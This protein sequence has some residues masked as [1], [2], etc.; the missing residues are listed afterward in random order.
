[1]I[2]K[3]WVYLDK[4][5]TQQDI[6]AMVQQVKMP[7]IF[8]VA[9]YNRQVKPDGAESYLKRSIS[10]LANP[11]LLKDM[12]KAVARIWQA[13]DAGETIVIYGDYD[14]DGITSTAML[15]DFLRAEGANVCYYIPSRSDEGYGINIMA[16]QKFKKAGVN[17]V[18][19]VDCGITAVGEVAFANSIG[20]SVV[21]TDHHIC[22]EKLPK[23]CAV[24]NPKQPGDGHPFSE[25][26][27]VGLC[28]KLVLAL[29]IHHGYSTREYFDRY[30]ELCAIGTIAD[31]VPLVDENRIMVSAG[32]K[33]LAHTK[34][35]GLKAL[36]SAA[37]FGESDRK[38]DATTVSFG[39]APRINAA[40]RIGEAQ[41]GVELLLE[42]DEAR[43]Y[44]LAQYLNREN[45]ER[46]QIEKKILK[47]V[48][49]MIDADLSFEKKQV[50]VLAKEGWHQGVIGI[51][52]SRLLE[53]YY[54]PT[55]LI[56]LDAE[57]VGKGSGRSIK[58][59]NLFEALSASE[60]ILLKFGGHELAAG[61]SIR[62]ENVDIL[63]HR[64]EQ[65]VAEHLNPEDRVPQLAI[66]RAMDPKEIHVPMAHMLQEA[67][68]P[69]GAANSEPVWA[70]LKA[71]ITMIRR[72]G[73]DERHVRLQ[74]S[75][76]G[77]VFTAVGFSM[78]WIA[79]NFVVGDEVDVAFCLQLNY[80]GGQESVQLMLKDVKRA[81]NL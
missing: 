35:P 47:E 66:D 65:Y 50:I 74:L 18:V 39:L 59:L 3:K 31:V 78:A 33:R 40:G 25:L 36:M 23:A 61:L 63:A 19:T 55:I 32:V 12:D 21:I 57:G 48:Q 73:E 71:K 60:D 46:Q 24:V 30:V 79:D 56:A 41:K 58:G 1:M 42:Q 44:T 38:I 4:Q 34:H 68:S 20:L 62:Q 8:A 15:Y 45:S 80:Y 54:K 13:V 27:G 7:D 43:A 64:L 2:P 49:E 67:L 14:V 22:Q 52:A 53:K 11:L 69:F 29:A 6:D 5:W 72:M 77:K 9:L 51:V 16:L 70:L 37:G 17:L 75:K 28:F 26:A 76:E 81:S 10:N